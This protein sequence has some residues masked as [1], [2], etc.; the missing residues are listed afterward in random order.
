MRL[1]ALVAGAAATI[2]SV[3]Y[4]QS[5]A[6][7]GE[8]TGTVTDPSGATIAGVVIEVS[9]A[10]TGFKRETKVTEAGLYRFTLLPLGSYEL[11]AQ[12]VGFADARRTGVTV[13]AGAAIT[14]NISLQVAGAST[15]IDVSTTAAITDSP[16]RRPNYQLRLLFAE[17]IMR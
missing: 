16:R 2:Q 12:A 11:L 5:A 15:A 8:I 14:V 1:L 13:N 4:G 6:I 9:N 10:A 17:K 7:N 3:A